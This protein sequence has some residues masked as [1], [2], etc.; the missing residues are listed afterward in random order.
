MSIHKSILEMEEFGQ[1]PKER[2]LRKGPIIVIV[3]VIIVAV[4]G[5]AFKGSIVGFV[6]KEKTPKCA[7]GVDNDEDGL[8]DYRYDESSGKITGDPDCT[9]IND[10]S[11]EKDCPGIDEVCNGMDDDCDGFIDDGVCP[12]CG[13]SRVDPGEECDGTELDGKECSDFDNFNT[14]EIK[15]I[16]CRF[17]TSGCS[18]VVCG[19][20]IIDEGEECDGTNWGVISGCEDFDYTGGTLKCTNCRFD[21]SSCSSTRPN[22]CFDYDGGREYDEVGWVY[23]ILNDFGYNST[24]KC[25]T[26]EKLKEYYCDNSERRSEYYECADLGDN[27]TIYVCEDGACIV[28]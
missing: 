21:K 4:A 10:D 22:S 20:S 18:E 16:D 23:G 3:I 25:I 19:N 27:E 15:C 1:L 6:A 14:G 13:N 28:D 26:S 9:S 7:D 12:F 24:D 8:I 5:L 2:V 11:E 17:D